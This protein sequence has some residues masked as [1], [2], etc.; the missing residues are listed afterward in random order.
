MRSRAQSTTPAITY[1]RGQFVLYRDPAMFW[2]GRA[3]HTFVCQVGHPWMDGTYDLKGVATDRIV[4]HASPDYMRLLSPLDAM[5][6]IDTAPLNQADTGAMTSAAA[7]LRQHLGQ[8]SSTL[9]ARP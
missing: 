5:R 2:T 1:M 4:E 8:D 6:D 3:G 7:W 9:A